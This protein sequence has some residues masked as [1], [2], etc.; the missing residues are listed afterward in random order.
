[1]LITGHPITLITRETNETL[2]AQ[3]KQ[4]LI[5]T[6]DNLEKQLEQ[7][8]VELKNIQVN[9]L[10]L[11]L[12]VTNENNPYINGLDMESDSNGNEYFIQL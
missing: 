11:V 3:L 10:E 8:S 1:M 5:Q 6:L 12:K 7:N 9:N 4:E 2:I